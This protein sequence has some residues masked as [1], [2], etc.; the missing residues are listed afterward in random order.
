[1]MKINLK[2]IYKNIL[3]GVNILNKKKEK[4]LL[5]SSC[6][7]PIIY[8]LPQI[9]TN[10]KNPPGR[11]IVNGIDSTCSRSCQYVD[12]FLE[13]LILLTEVF[14]KDTKHLLCILQDMEYTK[15]LFCK[16]RM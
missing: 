4:S 1:M 15:D 3:E 16:Q 14:L 7:D 6:K 12:N 13:R 9:H 5:P 10:K 11:L 2:L 8:H